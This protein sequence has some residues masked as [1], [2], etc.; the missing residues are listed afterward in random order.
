MSIEIYNDDCLNFMKSKVFA[1][2]IKNKKVCIVTDP[3][4]NVG[5][6]Y[7]SYK[8]NMKENDYYN[9]LN[10]IFN[11]YDIPFVV[12]HYS[13]SLYKL[14]HYTKQI[15]QKVVSWVYNSNTARQHRDIAFFKIKPDFEKVRQPYKNLNDKRIQQRIEN[16]CLGSRLYD[17]WEI[18]QVK[19]VSE[20]K[21]QHPCQMPLEVMENII[22]ILPE[23]YL[24][25]DPFS[26][27]G[28]TMIACKELKRDF[29]GCE[30]D[31]KYY[32][33]SLKRLEKSS[34]LFDFL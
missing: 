9:F 10:T 17:W 5:Y 1:E 13:E 29:I 30:I 28:T 24:I 7:N 25:F 2:L 11:M 20:E 3:P 19:N 16:G 26:G 31:E 18:N 14:S 15:P 6:H 4:F 22:G 32:K 34:N 12:I 33:L 8:D 27:S 23:D 21:T